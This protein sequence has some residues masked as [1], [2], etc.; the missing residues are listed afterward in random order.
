MAEIPGSTAAH[1]II[2][3]ECRQNRGDGEAWV[4]AARRMLAMYE[5]II[6]GWK[7]AEQQPTIHL[8]LILQRP[9]VV[10]ASHVYPHQQEG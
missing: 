10:D 8:A 2:T 9:V 6:D 7:D 1:A 4:E 3:P 5:S